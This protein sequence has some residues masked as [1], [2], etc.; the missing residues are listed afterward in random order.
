M[1]NNHGKAKDSKK[2]IGKLLSY[3]FKNYKFVVFK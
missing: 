2:T 3:L 1:K